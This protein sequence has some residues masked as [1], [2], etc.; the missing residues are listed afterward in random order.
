[1]VQRLKSEVRQ[2]M[3][4]AAEQ[5]FFEL[6]YEGATM[7][8]IARQACISTGNL[9]RYFGGKEALFHAIFTDAFAASL[10]K[11]LRRRVR[12]LGE[13]DLLQL[14]AAA[15]KEQQELLGF[16]IEH[17]VKVVVLLDRAAGSRFEGFRERFV[18]EIEKP[19]LAALRA[20]SGRKRLPQVVRFLL[21]NIFDNTVRTIVA[22]LQE[23]EDE[24]RI[25]E[26][27]FVFWSYQL[28]GLA[29]LEQWVKT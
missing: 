1:M 9:Y 24:A 21:R 11:I 19:T 4:Q 13:T 3:L 27:F 23:H 16:W 6:G 12:S 25:R 22:I 17:R 18:D 7:A 29:G 20:R 15:E 2:R 5:V 26:A 10:L 28:A 8:A 14:N